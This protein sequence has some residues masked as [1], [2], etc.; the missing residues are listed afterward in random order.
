M[1]RQRL[2]TKLRDSYRP[3]WHKLV[4]KASEYAPD[5]ASSVTTAVL[6]LMDKLA[7]RA[8]NASA[9]ADPATA[10]DADKAAL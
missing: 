1:A 5:S 8:A 10:G 6:D 7:C 2:K 9:G 4:E 3:F